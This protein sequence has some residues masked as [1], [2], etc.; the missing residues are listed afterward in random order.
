[1][2]RISTIRVWSGPLINSLRFSYEVFDANDGKW[3]TVKGK[4]QGSQNPLKFTKHVVELGR[5]EH[6]VS[7]CGCRC[8]NFTTS[9]AKTYHFGGGCP[10][11]RT[12][13][14]PQHHRCLALH[15]NG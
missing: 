14:I 3:K 15:A 12:V 10:P 13:I 1:M 9:T 6:I 5:D 2:Y 4:K 7:V 11:N 8:F